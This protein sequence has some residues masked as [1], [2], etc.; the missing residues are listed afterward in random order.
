MT[1]LLFS[2]LL[3]LAAPLAFG[4]T[5]F[6]G[7]DQIFEAQENQLKRLARIWVTIDNFDPQL[8][9]SIAQKNCMSLLMAT[10]ARMGRE[11]TTEEIMRL[12]PRI[13]AAISN[14]PGVV[15]DTEVVTAEGHTKIAHL[16]PGDE[17]ISY[18][19]N[20][21]E[22]VANKV[23]EVHHEVAKDIK[24]LQQGFKYFL[25]ELRISPTQKFFRPA[26]STFSTLA[27]M[28][29]GTFL[30]QI[31]SVGSPKRTWN[32]QRGSLSKSFK[33]APVLQLELAGE[34]HNFFAAHVL[35]Q[36]YVPLPA[37]STGGQ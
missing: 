37:E 13:L 14:P 8:A 11:L 4:S 5:Y 7:L 29:K 24:L 2:A 6:D 32:L 22:L 28:K 17:I 3:L 26:D 16:K 1:S 10:E 20:T 25:P 30:L 15:S 27:A 36:S 35:V 19:A 23:I 31:D 33:E 9:D 34:P 12:L 18:D 21:G